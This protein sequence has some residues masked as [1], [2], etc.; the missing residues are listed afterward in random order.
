MLSEVERVKRYLIKRGPFNFKR[1]KDIGSVRCCLIPRD[2]NKKVEETSLIQLLLR[3]G[4]TSEMFTFTLDALRLTGN[5]IRY[6][7]QQSQP[8]IRQQLEAS[9]HENN[10]VRLKN[11]GDRGF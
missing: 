6:N 1:A 5:V 4:E 11:G 3:Q 7:A 9:S 10:V 2:I 8:T